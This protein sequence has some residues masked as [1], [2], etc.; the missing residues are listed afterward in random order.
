[1]KKKNFVKIFCVL[2]TL[3]IVAGVL[4]LT[5]EAQESM[6][7]TPPIVQQEEIIPF[8]GTAATGVRKVSDSVKTQEI[9]KRLHALR[10][11]KTPS[12][13]YSAAPSYSKAPYKE[14]LMTKAYLQHIT[15]HVNYARYVAGL[16]PVKYDIE[17]SRSAQFGSTLMATTRYFAHSIPQGSKPAD[18]PQAFFNSGNQAV[19]SSNIGWGHSS[20]VL[21]NY[22]CLNDSDVS[23]IDRVGHRAWLL[24]D[25][26]GKIGFGRSGSFS[27]TKV[28]DSSGESLPAGEYVTW[29][30]EGVFPLE[31]IDYTYS[32]SALAWSFHYNTR[33]YSIE[34]KPGITLT[35]RSDK[36]TWKF[37]SAGSGEFYQTSGYGGF[38]TFIFRPDTRTLN[39]ST[40]KSGNVFDVSI[41]GLKKRASTDYSYTYTPTTISYSVKIID[42]TLLSRLE[43]SSPANTLSKGKTLK[44]SAVKTP[45]K[46][47]ESITWSSSDK[48]VA[49]VSSS[50]VVTAIKNGSVTI[51]AKSINGKK[52]TRLITVSP[53]KYVTLR[54]GKS[55]AV[56]NGVKTKIDKQ[57]TKPFAVS[58]RT[59]VPVRFISE[60][61][62]GKV[63][64]KNAK[65][66]IYIKYR[67]ITV[68]L[69]INQKKMKVTQGKTTKTITLDVAAQVKNNR[70]Y[71]PLRAISQALG[72][73]VYYHSKTKTI[74]ISEPKSTS[75]QRKARLAEAKSYIKK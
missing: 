20:Q 54:I 27:T 48:S 19:G 24:N 44:L 57:G 2:L 30:S 63:T 40:Y 52:A 34:G 8:S 71:V 50:G 73:N 67:D 7:N 51:T 12:N 42:T 35:R 56:Q 16:S 28:F 65:T 25:S 6:L 32:G 68:E 72:F 17:L 14:G 4:P 75:A 21:F 46:S 45:S 49:T 29:P 39:P 38:N 43:I 9:L 1:M 23:N 33:D 5:A 15:D 11:Y 66:P 10:K 59:M 31:L 64:Y 53:P 3:S 70:T 41:T 13:I 60:K 36:K 58:G 47:L 22:S 74:I 55:L 26:M 37:G 61:M 69:T 18:M 62:G